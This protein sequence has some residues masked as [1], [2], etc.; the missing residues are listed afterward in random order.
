MLFFVIKVLLVLALYCCMQLL[1]LKGAT[2]RCLIEATEAGYPLQARVILL[3]EFFVIGQ[4]LTV[5]K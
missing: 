5:F 3:D 4:V 2:Q 1:R